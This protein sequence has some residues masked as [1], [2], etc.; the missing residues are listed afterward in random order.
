MYQIK[1]SYQTGDSFGSSETDTTLDIEWNNIE[2]AKRNLVRIEEHYE[3]YELNNNS[4][5]SL[6]KQDKDS[7]IKE[8]QSRDWYRTSQFDKKGFWSLFLELDNG[9]MYAQSVSWCGYFE[10]LIGAEIILV[11]Q[12]IKFDRAHK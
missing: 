4:H 3:L 11:Y 1:V 12:G 7:R 10:S 6:K 2:A 5:Y 8:L 9:K